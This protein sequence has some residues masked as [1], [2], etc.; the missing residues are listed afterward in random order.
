MIK[1]IFINRYALYEKKIALYEPG[2]EGFFQFGFGIF[3]G[4]EFYSRNYPVTIENWR[5][6]LRTDH[7]VEKEYNGVM[8]R[9]YPSRKIKS[10]G[11]Y[12]DLFIRDLKK[13]AKDENVVFHFMGN[14]HLN[15]HFYSFLVRKRK[16]FVS[17]LGGGNPLWKYKI[18]GKLSTL[19]HYWLEKYLFLRN[20]NSLIT[21][22][23]AEADYYRKANIPVAFMPIMGIMREEIFTM[24]DRNECRE[25]LGLPKDKK[26]IL[27][28][29]RAAQNRGFDWIA[30]IIDHYQPFDEY[31]LVFAGIHKEDEYYEELKKRNVYMLDFLTH[32]ELPDYYNA[33][34]VLIFLLHNP[35]ELDFGGTGYVPLEAL[36]C[37]T[38]VV[39]TTFNSFPGEEISEVARI[40]GSKEEVIPMIEEL[41]T[42][43]IPR[44]RCREV[45]LKYFSW[46]EVVKKHFELYSK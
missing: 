35:E 26:I 22:S 9:I 20:Y 45:A 19:I 10:F 18:D 24:K 25:K 15:Y 32:L 44:Q 4:K 1:V 39:A 13:A 12:S 37:G 8:H 7:V 46:D 27:Q 21:L 33:A 30:E 43:G 29:G 34:D 6:D 17:H 3:F 23:G 41:L 42:T 28:V 31:L 2:A 38:P 36:A 11:E 40:P 14:H 5:M 16:I